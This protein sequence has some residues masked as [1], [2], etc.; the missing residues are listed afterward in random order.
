MGADMRAVQ[1]VL[2]TVIV[3]GVA[4]IALHV[5]SGDVF[6]GHVPPVADSTVHYQ[7]SSSGSGMANSV[8][9][10]AGNGIQQETGV[11]L[12]W[13]KD[14]TVAAGVPLVITAQSTGAGMI[15]CQ[16]LVNG[17][18]VSE[19]VSSGQFAVVVCSGR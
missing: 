3:G 13:S 17:A 10:G 2:I 15:A 9:Y 4:Y 12:P 6:S 19:H 5:L 18:V 1:A 16:I 11:A 7:V 14:F 8:T